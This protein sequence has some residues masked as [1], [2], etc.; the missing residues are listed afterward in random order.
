MVF[1]TKPYFCIEEYFAT[2]AKWEFIY[3]IPFGVILQ[4]SYKVLFII[5]PFIESLMVLVSAVY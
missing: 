5:Y 4:T 3:N 1:V 2:L